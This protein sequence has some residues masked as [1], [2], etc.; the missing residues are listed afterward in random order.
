MWGQNTN[1]FVVAGDDD[2]CIYHFLGADPDT[3]LTSLPDEQKLH[4]RRTHRM[5]RA[6]YDCAEAWIHDLCGPREEKHYRP[7]CEGGSVERSTLSFA[8]TQSLIDE[9]G[10]RVNRGQ[11]VMLL[12]SC[13]Y[14][15]HPLL[16]RLREEG[17]PF[18][19]PYRKNRGD[20]NPLRA[21]AR[22]LAAFLECCKYTEGTKQWNIDP[23]AWLLWLKMLQADCFLTTKKVALTMPVAA[24]EAWLEGIAS[25]DLLKALLRA[26]VKWLVEHMTTTAAKASQYPLLIHQQGGALK[27]K[28]RIV[29]GTI[30][31]V[32]GG[33]ADCVYLSPELS[34]EACQYLSRVGDVAADALRRLYYVGMT[35]ARHDLVLCQTASIGRRIQWQ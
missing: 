23:D 27:E 28:P 19:N 29:V 6:V 4:L 32:K 16:A 26:D 15:L 24:D 33:E 12:A 25:D 5:S 13:S 8:D 20:W 22:K 2:Q 11:T 34:Y 21:T 35:R 18:H 30:H 9:V 1:I 7:A 10:E 3:F 14:M 31:S 17:L